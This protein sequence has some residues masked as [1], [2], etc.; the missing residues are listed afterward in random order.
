MAPEPVLLM[1]WAL[2]HERSHHRPCPS[3]LCKH[4]MEAAA[5]W[6][7]LRFPKLDISCFHGQLF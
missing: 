4:I 6:R 3:G 7:M 2:Y 5:L 1:V